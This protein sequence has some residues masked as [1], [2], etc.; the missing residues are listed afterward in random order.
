M[1]FNLIT[2]IQSCYVD[3]PRLIYYSHIPTAVVALVF[4]FFVYF[5]NRDLGAK[6]LFF[7]S[8]IFSI[9]VSLNLYL[10]LGYDS[11]IIMFIGSLFG[12]LNVMIFSLAL[13]FSYVFI[14][15][16]DADFLLKFFLIIPISLA[17]IL[18]ENTGY[19][20]ATSCEVSGGLTYF[21]FIYTIEAVV[22]LWILVFGIYK[23]IKE[24]TDFRKQ[25][26]LLVVGIELFLLSFFVTGFLASYLAEK[27]VS[28][29]FEIEQYGLF[30]MT[31]FLGF[32]GYLI[33]KFKAFNI[34]LL[35]AQ[36]LVVAQ[37]LLIAS[38]FAFANNFTT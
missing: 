25:I 21:Y 7:I 18:N 1:N 9:W 31:I 2:N 19:F 6:I 35:S 28:Y 23:I 37:F 34:K 26:L 29:A 38:M 8:V 33:V 11:R 5:K 3:V 22:F 32:L 20:S 36:A 13:Y 16:K 17:S 12:T 15:R 24:K 10:W 27:G 4:G 30:G 14:N